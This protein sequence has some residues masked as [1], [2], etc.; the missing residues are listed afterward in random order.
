MK[1]YLSKTLILVTIIAL[2]LNGFPQIS[3]AK[4]QPLS[5]NNDN[6]AQNSTLSTEAAREDSS[7]FNS[8]LNPYNPDGANIVGELVDKRGK[9]TKQFR[10]A[11]GIIEADVYDSAVN[12]QKSDGTWAEV[13][14][15]LAQGKD[16][17][18]NSIFKTKDNGYMKVSLGQQSN[19]G[20]LVSITKGKYTIS[21]KF[22]GTS[23]LIPNVT[24]SP[25][26][27]P[28][29]SASAD[30]TASP[31][32]SPIDTNTVAP[33][34]T[35]SSNDTETAAPTTTDSPTDA[36][37]ATPVATYSSDNTVANGITES[38]DNNSMSTSGTNFSRQIQKA[39]AVAASVVDDLA[40]LKAKLNSNEQK[41]LAGKSK[42]HVEYKDILPGINF[43]YYI[44]AEKVKED[45]VVDQYTKG[46]AYTYDLSTNGLTATKLSDGTIAISD[47]KNNVFYIPVLKMKD[48]ANNESLNVSADLVSTDN[49]YQ[50]T[51]TPDDI[52][53]ANAVYPVTIDPIVQTTEDINDIQDTYASSKY[54]TTNYYTYTDLRVGYSDS[55]DTLYDYIQFDTDAMP[56]L[57]PGDVVVYAG[58]GL[59][60]DTNYSTSF[61]FDVH[62]VTSS[63]TSS[64]LT[65][66]N[67]PS[68][69]PTVSDYQTVSTTNEGGYI[70]YTWDI[71]D[72][73]RTWY[74]VD[75]SGISGNYGIEFNGECTTD[76]YRTFYSSDYGTVSYRP[77]IT[78]QYIN[79]AGLNG[80]YTYD[81][82]DAG[83]A[84]TASVNDLTGNLVVSED[85]I[86]ISGN[87]M[88]VSIS[89]VYNADMVKRSP[90]NIGYGI[91]WQL[92]YA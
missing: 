58:L 53:M 67:K 51:I 24:A 89:H 65:W 63:W 88:P 26:A 4:A 23:S 12:Y 47:G 31:N 3:T 29:E 84:G 54:P 10:K 5:G 85:D 28:T 72:I 8:S 19:L 60:S 25:D 87:R 78:I 83:R 9:F 37:T 11:D 92:N 6:D 38:L 81:S 77:S 62:K 49:G 74:G 33:T 46:Q 50:L 44:E 39:N 64:T 20:N 7:D 43:E 71:T 75:N 18:G 76:G 30:V 35:D 27:S 69:D 36:V 91:G 56:S 61:Q 90:N 40:D 15:T 73:A 42:S 45:I 82:L 55:Y 86:G 52:W 59:V 13:D 79:A 2:I 1:K 16:S 14:N 68:I 22:S 80:A 21:W 17:K 57:R 34:A 70:N 41:R 66:N 48:S 32:V